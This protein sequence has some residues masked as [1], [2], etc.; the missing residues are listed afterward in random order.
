MTEAVFAYN[1]RFPGQYFDSETGKHYNYFRD[2]DPAI[3]RYIESDP[4]GL[5]GGINTYA[6]VNGA[7]LQ[8][9]DSLGFASMPIGG[10]FPGQ[11]DPKSIA[12]AYNPAVCPQPRLWD[13]R[14][15]CKVVCNVKY[16][17]ICTGIG[18]FV[19]SGGTPVSGGIAGGGCVILKG[20]ICDEVC[21]KDP[22][23]CLK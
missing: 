4:I 9:S 8:F 20:V 5:Q 17:F 11:P 3:G 22:S 23:S 21:D 15:R 13:A 10:P 18:L 7:P 2:Y 1:L 6:Y 12:C 19:G 16:Q 14:T